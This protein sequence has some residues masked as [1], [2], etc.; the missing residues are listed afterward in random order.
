MPSSQP[1]WLRNG[2]FLL[3]TKAHIFPVYLC[4][5]VSTKIFADKWI[6]N[7]CRPDSLLDTKSTVV[8]HKRKSFQVTRDLSSNYR[9]HVIIYNNLLYTKWPSEDCILVASCSEVASAY[10]HTAQQVSLIFL[11]FSELNETKFPCSVTLLHNAL[12][13]LNV[14]ADRCD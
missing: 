8:K 7:F 12:S 9:N 5:L 2:E 14:S 4:L 10:I 3:P 6:C 11:L 1:P 13:S